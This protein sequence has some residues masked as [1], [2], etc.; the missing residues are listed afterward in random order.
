LDFKGIDTVGRAF[1]DEIFRVFN[2]HHP[3]TEILWI[4]AVPEI[5]NMTES[6]MTNDGNQ[7]EFWFED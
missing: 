3:G 2:N 7:P 1:I 5:E 6:V 4:N